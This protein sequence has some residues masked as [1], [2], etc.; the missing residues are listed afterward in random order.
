KREIVVISR[1]PP[2]NFS[3]KD[4]KKLIEMLKDKNAFIA[5]D[6]AKEHLK[7]AIEEEVHF[8]KPNEHEI[9]YLYPI[10]DTKVKKLHRI[11]KKV[12]YAVCSLGS[13]GVLYKHK[14]SFYKITTPDV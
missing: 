5:C 11:Y 7:V 2:H 8:V 4:Y 13:E 1:S 12:P 6:V 14:N 10:E 3:T 9:E